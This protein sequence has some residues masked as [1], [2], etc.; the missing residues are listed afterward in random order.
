MSVEHTRPA[1]GPILYSTADAAKLLCCGKTKVFEL[2][3]QG[4]LQ[5]VVIGRSRLVRADSVHRLAT[6]GTGP[7]AA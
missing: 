6:E 2:I 4:D 1:Q 7:K 3:R 5:T